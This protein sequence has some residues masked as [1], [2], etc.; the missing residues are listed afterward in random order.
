MILA[1][2][3]SSKDVNLVLSKVRELGRN[4]RFAS[5]SPAAQRLAA[6][7]RL[8]ESIV[9]LERMDSI[10]TVAKD[11][12]Q[13][14]EAVNQWLREQTR[15]LAIPNYVVEWIKWSE[16]G[17]TT[18]RL[19]DAV[20]LLNSYLELLDNGIQEVVL[21]ARRETRFEDAVLVAAAQARGIPV[22]FVAK[23][24]DSVHA[25][26]YRYRV[27]RM[28]G[29]RYRTAYLPL[30]AL[31]WYRCLKIAFRILWTRRRADS[32]ESN[33]RTIAFLVCQNAR[34]H[35]ANAQF[36]MRRIQEEPSVHARALCFQ[37]PLADAEFTRT[38][39]DSLSIEGFVSISS[40][41]RILAVRK[42][43]LSRAYDGERSFHDLSGLV[44]RGVNLSSV[45]WPFVTLFLSRDLIERIV[46]KEGFGSYLRKEWPIALRT[47]GENI[48]DVGLIAFELLH[49]S[50]EGIESKRTLVFDYPVGIMAPNPYFDC[51]RIPDRVFVSG[52][53]DKDMYAS[54]NAPDENVV[55][56]GFGRGSEIRE[57]KQA[58]TREDSRQHLR[59]GPPRRFSIF[60]VPSGVV[61]GYMSA[62]EHVRVATSLVRLVNRRTDCELL[63]KPHP[64][65]SMTAWYDLLEQ[66]GNTGDAVHLIDRR[67]SPLHC[68]NAAD[69]IVTKFSTVALEAMELER[70]VISIALDA[71]SGFQD[72]FED[73]VL[74]FTDCSAFE[75]SVEKL[76]SNP[77]RFKSWVSERLDI[78]QRF[79]PRKMHR[80]VGSV[81][82]EIVTRLMES[83]QKEHHR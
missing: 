26:R 9:F 11:V 77:E 69:V 60:Y 36:V 37:A 12:L 79:L 66:L 51:D 58:H 53:L 2:C 70:P 64:G 76:F 83:L 42:K 78:Q 8:F 67:D 50:A 46:F 22:T 20:L 18:Q 33:N 13:L 52:V 32:L 24:Q 16:G 72:I 3:R 38:G 39:V 62:Q 71:E 4:A 41:W 35:I 81:E 6:D 31:S 63:I 15:G 7:S 57:F 80:P 74:K 65:E 19:Q 68:V 47:W 49:E 82:A 48:L 17:D 29:G 23:R 55:V 5:D 25:K 27:E 28:L 10:F 56:T 59:L 30:F 54:L 14:R 45:L 34:K 73:S 43:V 40:Y 61:R 44:Y 75:Q 21:A 1:V